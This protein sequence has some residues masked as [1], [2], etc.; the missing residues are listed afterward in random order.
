LLD[1]AHPGKKPNMLDAGG[2]FKAS[3]RSLVLLSALHDGAVWTTAE[4]ARERLSMPEVDPVPEAP[5]EEAP[6]EEA[7]LEASTGA[8]AAAVEAATA[9]AAETLEPEGQKVEPS[10]TQ[11]R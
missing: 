11:T 1:T 10:E 8:E 4:P 6:L 5:E 3:G 9:L 2:K 7:P